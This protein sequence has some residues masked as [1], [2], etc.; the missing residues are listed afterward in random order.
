MQPTR[1][2]P[3]VEMHEVEDEDAYPP[4]RAPRNRHC[5]IVSVDDDEEDPPTTS[6]TPAEAEQIQPSPPP[7]AEASSVQETAEQELGK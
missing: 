6:G 5:V 4:V 2:S 1:R 3:S 7:A